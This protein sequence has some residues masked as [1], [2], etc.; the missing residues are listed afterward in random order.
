MVLFEGIGR[1]FVM[2][3]MKL[4][5]DVSE[6]FANAPEVS[7]SL[8]LGV[9][10]QISVAQMERWTDDSALSRAIAIS[11]DQFFPVIGSQ[12]AVSF[13]EFLARQLRAL[14][15][16]P[17]M[18]PKLRED[19]RTKDFHVW[20]NELP[21]G[22]EN[23]RPPNA[24]RDGIIDPASILG[25]IFHGPIGPLPPVPPRPAHVYGHMQFY[26]DTEPDDVFY[27]YE[28]F[29]NS[30]RVFQNS[31]KGPYVKKDTCA[32]PSSEIQF[33]ATGFGAVARFALPTLMPARWRWE[34]Q[35]VSPSRIRMGASVPLYGQAGGGVEIMFENDT[36]NRGPIANQFVLP[37]L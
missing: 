1:R 32:A 34:L 10:G 12:V 37:I 23:L 35:P 20:Y 9:R 4:S 36:L 22:P 17:W 16:R 8:Q 29:P 18:S 5:S 7:M 3:F 27:R 30:L 6:A 33:V 11:M 15:E 28:Y 24:T 13:D 25:V 26:G 31:P 19:Q 21:D 14:R 2:P